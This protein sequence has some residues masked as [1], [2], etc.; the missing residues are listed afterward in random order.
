MVNCRSGCFGGL[1]DVKFHE[2][3]GW[4]YLENAGLT[5]VQIFPLKNVLESYSS[6]SVIVF[7]YFFQM[8][9]RVVPSGGNNPSGAHVPIL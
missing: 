3:D 6:P 7:K 2:A 5:V 1:S 4:L 9:N 8:S